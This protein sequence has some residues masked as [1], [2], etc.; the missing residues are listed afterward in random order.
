[1]GCIFL[2]RK[3][4]NLKWNFVE[5]DGHLDV[6]VSQRFVN[7]SLLWLYCVYISWYSVEKIV[8]R[9]SGLWYSI[10]RFIY[11][12]QSLTN[13]FWTLY[14]SITH[15][16][17]LKTSLLLKFS[18]NLTWL[19]LICHSLP[20]CQKFGHCRYN[21]LISTLKVVSLERARLQKISIASFKRF[22]NWLW[23]RKLFHVS[24]L[25]WLVLSFKLKVE[26]QNF[27]FY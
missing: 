1:M 23:F 10:R 6:L 27:Y 8:W 20:W 17:V 7:K 21:Y 22:V 16:K 4:R 13:L 24:I 25:M 12:H 14:L 9:R 18:I 3:L 19:H 5:Q 11:G 2:F 26:V 15:F